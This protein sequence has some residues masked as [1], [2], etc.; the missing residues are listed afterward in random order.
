MALFWNTCFGCCFEHVRASQSHPLPCH[1]GL[2][3]FVLR[4][5]AESKVDWNFHSRNTS[6][7]A[8]PPEQFQNSTS[9]PLAKWTQERAPCLQ[10]SVLRPALSE[11]MNFSFL[12]RSGFPLQQNIK[13]PHVMLHIRCNSLHRCVFTRKQVLKETLHLMKEK[14]TQ[15]IN[16]NFPARQLTLVQ[17]RVGWTPGT[18]QLFCHLLC[19][20]AHGASSLLS[21]S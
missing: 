5:N 3:I 14:C 21:S 16:W 1:S 15:V 10:F 18:L 12:K 4:I 19:E 20:N 7:F 13:F 11:L 8:S 17:N 9:W 6:S 2:R